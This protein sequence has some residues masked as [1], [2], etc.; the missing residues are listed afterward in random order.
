MKQR[1]DVSLGALGTWITAE[2]GV[3]YTPAGLKNML[4][5]QLGFQGLLQ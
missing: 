1:T 5:K 4:K 3:R 2:F